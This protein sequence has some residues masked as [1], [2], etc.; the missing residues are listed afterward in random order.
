[1]SAESWDAAAAILDR[2]TS[3]KDPIGDTAG[4]KLTRK[5]LP[6]D[7][8]LLVM[9]ET[10]Q[11]LVTVM[12]TFRSLEGMIPDFPKIGKIKPLKGAPTFVG[13]AVTLKGDLATVNVFVPAPAIS[14]TR[15]LL[16]NLFHNI[17]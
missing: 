16:E 9:L 17:E 5:N 15:K 4:Y 3:A 11:S 2:F 13:I 8:S 1:M 6:K 7:A 10:E 14:V 12:D